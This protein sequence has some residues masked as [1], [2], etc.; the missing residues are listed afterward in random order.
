MEL[1]KSINQIYLCV[2]LLMLSSCQRYGT[3]KEVVNDGDT[4]FSIKQYALDQAQMFGGVPHSLYRIVYLDGK[5]DSTITNLINMDWA[6]IFQVFGASDISPK[7]FIGQYDFASY[8][9]EATASRGLIYT[10]KREYPHLLTR[11]LQINIDPSNNKITSIYIET[12]KK[13]FWGST[14][15]KLLYVPL[16]VIQIQE[17][18]HSLLGKARNLRVDYRFLREDDIEPS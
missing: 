10:A 13:D 9:D 5:V 4:Y 8:E 1:R 11:T 17:E 18:Q 2:F 7:K 6:S 12:A 16:R 3:S 14:K 15:Q